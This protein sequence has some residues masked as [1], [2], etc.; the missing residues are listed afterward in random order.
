MFITY[1]EV[2]AKLQSDYNEL[3]DVCAFRLHEGDVLA[4][5]VNDAM[6]DI[7]VLYETARETLD[8]ADPDRTAGFE[9]GDAYVFG[10]DDW[11]N[12]EAR[13]RELSMLTELAEARLESIS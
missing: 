8:D 5:V 12:Y 2:V 7:A 1:G 13:L 9:E 10:S 6:A 11:N 4:R 3:F